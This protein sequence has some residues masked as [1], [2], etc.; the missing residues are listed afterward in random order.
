MR[1]RSNISV[2]TSIMV[3][4]ALFG[5]F[6]ALVLSIPSLKTEASFLIPLSAL[7]SFVIAPFIGSSMVPALRSKSVRREYQRSDDWY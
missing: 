2:L 4:A 3:H 7:A 6:L 1:P 5:T